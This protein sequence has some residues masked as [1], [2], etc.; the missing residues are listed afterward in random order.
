MP[1]NDKASDEI[2]LAQSIQH[3]AFT[4]DLKMDKI[5]GEV[6][7]IRETMDASISAVKESVAASVDSIRKSVD[8]ATELNDEKVNSL[9]KDN[10]A[11]VIEIERF[12]ESALAR[13]SLITEKFENF[14]KRLAAVE[15]K[16]VQDRAKRFDSAQKWLVGILLGAVAG[17]LGVNFQTLLTWL[18]TLPKGGS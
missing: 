1:P 13:H 14:D 3:L 8:H 5:Q 10:K 18:A 6:S 15:G 2:N 16:D 17:W 4:L 11:V 7:H 12:E 9:A